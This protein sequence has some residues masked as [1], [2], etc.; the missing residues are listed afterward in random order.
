MTEP[1][2]PAE[3]LQS[4]LRKF[5]NREIRDWFQD[6]DLDN[7]DIDIPRQSMAMAC[8]HLDEDS[9]LMTVSRQ[10]FFE[11][12]RGRY[13]IVQAGIGETS[14]RTN[15]RRQTKPKIT[16]YFLEDLDDVEPGYAPVYGQISIR[17]M[18]YTPSTIT[19][20]IARTYA[21]RIRTLFAA[22]GGFV[23]RKGKDMASYSD[24]EKGYQLQLLSRSSGDAK[25]VVEQILDI[26]NDTPDWSFFNYSQN[27]RALEAYPTIPD[28]DRAYGEIRRQPRR[29]PIASVRF[30]TALLHVLGVPTPIPLVDRSGVY[31][32]ALAS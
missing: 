23:W 1:Q 26:Q 19:E 25:Q 8:R 22:G 14:Y 2:S 9:L 31:P 3:H 7:L 13:A 17:L 6:V 5:Y 27:D 24:W 11:N 21:N 20:T 30:Q 4:T 32:N 28:R 10:M 12:I 29:R 16:L 15:V 18:D